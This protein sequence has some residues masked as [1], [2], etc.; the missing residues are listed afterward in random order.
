MRTNRADAIVSVRAQASAGTEDEFFHFVLDGHRQRIRLHQLQGREFFHDGACRLGG[1]CFMLANGLHFVRC[2]FSTI[3]VPGQADRRGK[4]SESDAW[5]L[6]RE[7]HA[8]SDC[9]R[10]G[11]NADRAGQDGL[12]SSA[13][14]PGK[15]Q[16]LL[17]SVT[18]CKRRRSREWAGISY[19]LPPLIHPLN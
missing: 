3:I 13:Q 17:I 14:A 19:G 8:R 7:G 6:W 15:G 12:R 9:V 10:T 16:D 1:E 2:R 18:L 11:S 5:A 4:P